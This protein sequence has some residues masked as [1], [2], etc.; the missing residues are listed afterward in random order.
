ML[1]LHTH[2]AYRCD[3][4]GCHFGNRDTYHRACGYLQQT[5]QI[6][7]KEITASSPNKAVIS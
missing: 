6:S 1:F 5:P 2:R 4:H 3:H 7:K